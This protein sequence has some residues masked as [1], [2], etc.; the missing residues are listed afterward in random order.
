MPKRNAGAFRNIMELAH[1][2]CSSNVDR[3]GNLNGKINGLEGL[4]CKRI[5]EAF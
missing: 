5:N 4:L 1:N 3:N 2:I